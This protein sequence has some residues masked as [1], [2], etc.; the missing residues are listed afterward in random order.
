MADDPKENTNLIIAQALEK[1]SVLLS[2]I[3]E[4]KVLFKSVKFTD[5]EK[6]GSQ[7]EAN[8]QEMASRL[9]NLTVS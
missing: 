4:E 3:Q 6:I 8:I 7:I 2:R 1:V 5:T 9:F